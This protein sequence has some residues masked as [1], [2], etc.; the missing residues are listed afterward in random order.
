VSHN[1]HHNP[2]DVYCF[3]KYRPTYKITCREEYTAEAFQK[4]KASVSFLSS[5]ETG[6]L[7]VFYDQQ[8]QIQPGVVRMEIIFQKLNK[9]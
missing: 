2:A 5:C 8:H 7:I 9:N 6:N 4:L 1:G 3:H